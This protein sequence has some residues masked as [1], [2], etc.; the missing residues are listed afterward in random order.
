MAAMG[1]TTRRD[2]LDTLLFT[3]LAATGVGLL[4]PLPFYLRPPNRIL[5]RASAG[6]RSDLSPG[7]AVA[8]L[9]G[10]RPAIV[11]NRDGKILAFDATCTHANCTVEWKEGGFFCPCHKGKFDADGKPASGPVKKSLATLKVEELPSG[12]LM[13]GG[14]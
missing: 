5:K 10:G 2:F 9:Y 6:M 11:V 3:S 4:G 7:A 14:E 12:E 8:V 13:V 1:E